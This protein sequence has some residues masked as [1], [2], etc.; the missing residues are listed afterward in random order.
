MIDYMIDFQDLPVETQAIV[1]KIELL[2][3]DTV[4]EYR[5][6]IDWPQE[7]VK[8][9]EDRYMFAL[10]KDYWII[11]IDVCPSRAVKRAFDRVM[12]Y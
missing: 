2:G 10:G 3:F 12:A 8:P 4:F 1:Q 7:D 5:S 9:Q 6:K 11:E